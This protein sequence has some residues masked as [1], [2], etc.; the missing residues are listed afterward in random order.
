MG[1]R[2][3]HSEIHRQRCHTAWAGSLG[4]HPGQVGQRRSPGPLVIWRRALVWG[5]AGVLETSQVAPAHEGEAI[6]DTEILVLADPV[7]RTRF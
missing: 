4:G 6:T 7:M 3:P 1:L 2:N 5:G